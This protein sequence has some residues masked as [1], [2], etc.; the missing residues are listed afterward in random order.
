[1]RSCGPRARRPGLNGSGFWVGDATGWASLAVVFCRIVS[2]KHLVRKPACG[3]IT[4]CG[5]RD[6]EAAE[7]RCQWCG[8]GANALLDQR[9]VQLGTVDKEIHDLRSPVRC[10][11][12]GALHDRRYRP[13]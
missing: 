4:I 13:G 12:A 10:R 9:R 6:A 11:V 3:I 7:Y 2:E 8:C 1:L 5:V